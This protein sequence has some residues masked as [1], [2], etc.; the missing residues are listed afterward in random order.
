MIIVAQRCSSAKVLI[1]KKVFSE[2][3]SGLLL[4]VGVEKGDNQKDISKVVDK[5]INLRVFEDNEGKMNLSV[6]DI[7]GSI[8]A[9][10]QFTLCANVK[11]GRRPSFVNAQSPDI[12]L[13]LYKKL[14]N[15]F[16]LKGVKTLEGL[17]GEA[18]NVELN[19]DGPAT[20]IINSNKL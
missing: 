1:N 12:S 14:T 10:S 20:F 5:I 6:L 17:F 15:E 4:L 3:K 7:A 8:L 16:R 18:M 2:I 19:N 9:V 13:D 11:K